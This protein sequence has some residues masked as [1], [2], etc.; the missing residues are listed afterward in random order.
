MESYAKQLELYQSARS[1]QA[2]VLQ[3]TEIDSWDE[4]LIRVFGE[5]IMDLRYRFGFADPYIDDIHRVAWLKEIS[6]QIDPV[7]DRMA[8]LADGKP[9]EGVPKKLCMFLAEIT[10]DLGWVIR[11]IEDKHPE[12]A[13]FFATDRRLYA[14]SRAVASE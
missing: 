8:E 11:S 2:L 10:V 1:W 5:F 7:L 9:L 3:E 6:H 13:E 4:L 12:L 14:A